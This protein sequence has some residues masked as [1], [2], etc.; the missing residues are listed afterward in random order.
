MNKQELVRV[1]TNQ[2]EEIIKF[3][4]LEIQEGEQIKQSYLPFLNDLATI[5]EQSKK[6]NF[7]NPTSIDESIA[8][9]LRLKTVKVRTGASDLKDSRK[10]IHLLKGNLEQASFNLISASCKLA[11]ESFM[12]IEKAREI[13]EKA[14]KEARKSTRIEKLNTF[15]F[16]YS[17]VDLLN[18]EDES[19]D[20]LISTLED[21]KTAKIEAEK[22]AEAERIAREKA[23]QERIEAQRVEN[24]KLKAEAAEK[25]KQI[26]KERA[27][28][29]AK[30]KAIEAK[31]KAEADKKE[32]ELK[33]ERKKQDKIQ[34]E[35]REKAE[36]ERKEKERI[37]LEL[38]AKKEA[39]LKAEQQRIEVEN[40]AKKEADKIAKAPIKKQLGFWVDSFSLPNC[41]INNETSRDIILK[42]DAFKNWS[43]TQINNL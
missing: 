20:K 12:N 8:R 33:I 43:K 34:A 14:Q 37:E 3:S 29:E 2:L 32:A 22:K 11:E 40:I 16:D 1:E 24:E 41:A 28:A 25:E 31:A 27:E 18:M 42:F 17:F 4:G 21:A 30:Q 15:D 38:K 7:E 36:S 9:E 19:F 10:K 39:E 26:A 13:A 5:Q 35:L 6:I 23:E